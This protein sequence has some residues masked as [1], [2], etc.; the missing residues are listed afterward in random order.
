[1]KFPALTVVVILVAVG[2]V[3]VWALA[4]A[5]PPL[6]VE[7]PAYQPV[8]P[9]HP[10]GAFNVPVGTAGCLASACHGAPAEKTLA[11]T[12]DATTWQSSGSCWAAA[13]PHS[14]AYSLLTEKPHRRVKI[15]AAQIMANYAPGT[16]AT[17]DARCVACHTNPTLANAER[18]NNPHARVLRNEG[19]SCE[20]CHGNAGGWV[21]AHTSWTGKRDE[22]YA[23]TGMTPLYDL[24]E[25][26]VNCVGCHVGAPEDNGRK[27]P[28]RDMNHDM[29]AAGHP[30]L[31]F[32]FAEYM[33]RLPPHW[34]EKDRTQT[35]P[36]PRM[37]NPTKVWLVGRAAHAE[38][39]CNLL[40]SRAE[41]SANDPKTPWPEF[42]E[43]N[44]A[45]CHH[46]LK[47]PLPPDQNTKVPIE[48][49]DWR[50][51]KEYTLG[52][53]LG[54]PS[55]QVIWPMTHTAGIDRPNIGEAPMKNVAVAMETGRFKRVGIP[56][57]AR[58]DAAEMLRVR[59]E[60]LTLDDAVVFRRMEGLLPKQAPWLPEWDSAAQMYYALAA[61]ERARGGDSSD[62]LPDFRKALFALR[63]DD[64]PH[65]KW[66]AVNESLSEIRKKRP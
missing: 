6:S 23:K 3:A 55:W 18:F 41:R 42:A 33:R 45:A 51:T 60:L 16:K 57:I 12:I 43:Y 53:P 14:A 58:K 56:E 44:C 30:R 25:R 40:A 48:D 39:A 31:N 46:S 1:M 36:K 5:K 61:M 47:A 19:V 64:W 4:S 66:A 59:K 21:T 38:A 11:G 27:F 32:D 52:R 63:T 10:N 24:G 2:G 7:V 65:F 62:V 15:T 17:E 20:A 9:S 50:K 35:P 37:L 22:V 34:Q 49:R 13:D 8:P 54:T 28:V 26:A 29:I